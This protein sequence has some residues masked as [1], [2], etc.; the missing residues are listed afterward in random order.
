LDDD[1]ERC[2]S[3][4]EPVAIGDRNGLGDQSS[5]EW[6]ELLYMEWVGDLGE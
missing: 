3:G 2:A 4:E 6:S 1:D 5:M